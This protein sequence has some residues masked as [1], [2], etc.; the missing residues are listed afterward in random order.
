MSANIRISGEPL[1]GLST[2][3]ALQKRHPYLANNALFDQ[4]IP[5]FLSSGIYKFVIG[6]YGEQALVFGLISLRISAKGPGVLVE[7]LWSSGNA[8]YLKDALEVL[9]EQSKAMG[10]LL[11]IP[12]RALSPT[13][14]ALLSECAERANLSMTQELVSFLPSGNGLYTVLADPGPSQGARPSAQCFVFGA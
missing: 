4:S 14:S 10:G 11:Y 8:L 6:T 2:L 3:M 13:A 9:V 5:G 1:D 12:Q 7:A